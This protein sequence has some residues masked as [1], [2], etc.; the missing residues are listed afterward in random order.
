ML[1]QPNADEILE[2]VTR[3][4]R[5]QLTGQ[6]QASTAF[7]A[8]VAANALDLVRRQIAD[9]D[10]LE[11]ESHA[12]LRALLGHDGQ[13]DALERELCERIRERRLD[14]STPGLMEHL[15]AST[16][17]KMSIDQPSYASY[18]RALAN[19]E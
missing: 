6:Q 9:G 15:M 3:W 5:E 7:Q 4:L 1:D 11:R 8:R 14:A 18:R 19:K 2:V 17:A 16:L 10:R 13:A 12:R